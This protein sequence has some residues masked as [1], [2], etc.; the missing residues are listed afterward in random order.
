MKTY[1]M[2]LWDYLDEIKLAKEIE[3]VKK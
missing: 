2:K 3:Q 1:N